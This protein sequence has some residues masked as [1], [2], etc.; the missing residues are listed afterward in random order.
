MTLGEFSNIVADATADTIVRVERGEI[1]TLG[2]FD[3]AVGQAIM[4]A[5]D[6]IGPQLAEKLSV[7]IEPATQKAVATARPV[8]QQLLK[9][10]LPMFAGIVGLFTA[11]AILL[12]VGI[13]KERAR[14][15]SNPGLGKIPFP[16]ILF[17]LKHLLK[18]KGEPDLPPI[19]SPTMNGRHRYN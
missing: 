8:V 19:Q 15:K 11:G 3:A 7:W 12:G 17:G 5:V 4:A 13:S 10:N 1:R 14:Y 16:L 18:K 6:K 9:E 2:Q